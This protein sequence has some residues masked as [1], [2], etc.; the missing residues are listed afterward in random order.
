MARFKEHADLLNEDVKWYVQCQ[1]AWSK[2]FQSKILGLCTTQVTDLS[3]LKGKWNN[4]KPVKEDN[5]IKTNAILALSLAQKYDEVVVRCGVQ[6]EITKKKKKKHFH[7]YAVAVVKGKGT[8][9]SKTKR[10][11]NVSCEMMFDYSHG[12][13]RVWPYEVYEAN[14]WGSKINGIKP[15]QWRQDIKVCKGMSYEWVMYSI[16]ESVSY[17]RHYSY[18]MKKNN[19]IQPY[20]ASMMMSFLQKKRMLVIQEGDEI[21]FAE[22][23]CD[24]EECRR[25]DR[26]YKQMRLRSS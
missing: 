25:E 8:R 10:V 14:M 12:K 23:D 6:L 13:R 18:L 15:E 19:R 24:C 4:Y 2:P 16:L 26:I 22:N 11:K 17:Q 1:H 20:D 7:C 3:Y 9:K 21:I 5:C